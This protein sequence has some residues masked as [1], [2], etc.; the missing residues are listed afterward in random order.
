MG[1]ATL[2]P[3][4]IDRRILKE[5]ACS[6][7]L[8][9]N[10]SVLCDGIGPRFAGTAGY[11]QAAEFMLGRFRA[12]KL[13]NPH[14]EPF[15]FTA[16]RRGEPSTL[17]ML[18]PSVR[19]YDCYALCYSAATPAKGVTARVV[20]I[21][22]GSEAEIKAKQRQIKGRFVLTTGTSGHRTA[23]YARCADLGAAGFILGSTMPGMLLQTGTVANGKG[24]AIPAVNIALES[25]LQIKRLAS[26][27]G[28]TAQLHLRV[29]VALEADVTW[30]VVGELRGTE[31][32]DEWVLI[33]GHLDSHEIGPGA[34]DNG[35]GALMVMEVAR[36][37]ARQRRYLKRTIR[38]IGFAAE[39]I[40]LLGS[41]YHAKAHAAELRKAR[42]MLNCD[43]P[44]L[45]KPHGFGFHECPKAEAY[46]AGLSKA[47]GEPILFQ[48][49][50]HCHSD[51]YPFILQR[52]PTAG[53]ASGP[54]DPPVKHFY[55]MAADTAD[56]V[57]IDDLQATAAFA[58]RALL[59]IANDANWPDM[60]RSKAEVARWK[61]EE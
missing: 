45:G 19:D 60:Q 34:Y 37:L 26:M 9:R 25:L 57:R 21:G 2:S 52:V 49:R 43:T 18:T 24:G 38:F 4:A 3:I 29:D 5:A 42:F 40:G 51:H 33:G 58:A 8:T 56:K 22:S 31:V 17:A 35:A 30:N 61:R 28:G 15:P 14:L 55:H 41:H 39:E 36:L 59:R 48:N 20:D 27:P 13:D 46:L 12:C 1:N 6:A 53:V 16:W 54:Q 23:I 44:M 47:M 10:L 50:H 32:P 7:E 11:R